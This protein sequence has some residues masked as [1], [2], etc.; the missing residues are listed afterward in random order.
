LDRLG[1]VRGGDGGF[2]GQVRDRSGNAQ[3]AVVGA[4]RKEQPGEGMTLELAPV[5][6]ENA[7]GRAAAA[8]GGRAAG[9][10]TRCFFAMA[11]RYVTAYVAIRRARS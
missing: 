7:L 2:A 6:A 11:T 5:R 8:P 9:A 3:D 4:R 10:G 1:D